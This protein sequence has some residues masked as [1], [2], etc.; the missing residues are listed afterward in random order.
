[1]L[2]TMVSVEQRLELQEKLAIFNIYHSSN[3]AITIA[4]QYLRDEG[5]TV[6]R[7][8]CSD[9][10]ISLHVE[11]QDISWSIIFSRL[12]VSHAS[13]FL[14]APIFQILRPAH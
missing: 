4:R 2:G 8:G 5:A 6:M 7:E 11:I 9:A 12:T 1:M 10:Q 13:V 14:E 3:T